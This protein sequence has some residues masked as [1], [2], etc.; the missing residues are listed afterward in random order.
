M[1]RFSAIVLSS[2]CIVLFAPNDVSCILLFA[3]FAVLEVLSYFCEV[4]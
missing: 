1:F 2:M 4:E 3:L